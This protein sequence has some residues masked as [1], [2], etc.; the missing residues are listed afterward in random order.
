MA[1]LEPT[2]EGRSELRELGSRFFGYV[3]P[4]SDME[5]VTERLDA[6][7]KQYPD[8]THI[9]YAFRLGTDGAETRAA[10]DGEPKYSSGLP[11]L[12]QIKSAGQTNVLVA[13][14]RYY[15]G[16]KLGVPGLVKAYG[17]AAAEALA[18]VATQEALD[19]FSETVSVSPS[20]AGIV[21]DLARKHGA[22][23]RLEQMR[24]DGGQVI[25]LTGKGDASQLLGL[26]KDRLA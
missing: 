8:A 22:Q 2:T 19:T 25:L 15:G 7:H 3:Y 13:V 1:L 26:L 5:A 6:L 14:V 17:G 11:I 10:D 16:T 23:A 21:Y 4:A 12:N 18:T 24:D 20:K 9:C